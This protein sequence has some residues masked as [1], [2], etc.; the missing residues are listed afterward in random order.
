MIKKLGELARKDIEIFVDK[1][2]YLELFVK[3]RKD[4]RKDH[5]FLKNIF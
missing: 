5:R 4:W 1:E 3:V 2:V